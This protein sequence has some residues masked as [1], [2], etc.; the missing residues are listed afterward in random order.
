MNVIKNRMLAR[1]LSQ[2]GEKNLN[3]DNYDDTGKKKRRV[4][5]DVLLDA[6]EDGNDLTM[7]EM[8]QEVDTFM[9]AV[10]NAS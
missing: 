4:F 2:A 5:L 1:K 3:S 8:I 10:R 9:F 6:C 7:A